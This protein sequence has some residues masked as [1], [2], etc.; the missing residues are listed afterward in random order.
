MNAPSPTSAAPTSAAP[1]A[2]DH[3]SVWTHLLR[4][5]FTQGYVNAGG[6]RTRYIQAGDR[7]APTVIMIPG[8]ASSWE[9]FCANI[10]AHAAHFNCLAFDPVGSGFSE[11]PDVD[12]EIPVYVNHLLAFM[13]AMGVQ[14]ASLIGVSLGAWI[15]ARV[16]V[17]HPKRV[18][19]L[20]L[21]AA[22]G[23][24][25]HAQTMGRIRG[26]RTAA[27]DDPVW[28][29]IKS[30]FTPLIYR[31]EDRIDDIVAVRQVA[32]RQPEMRRAMDH[33]LCLQDPEVRARNLLSEDEWRSIK[34]PVLVVVAPDD[35]EMF[36]NTAMRALKLIPN[37]QSIEIR[38]VKHWPHFERPELFNPASIQFLSSR[39]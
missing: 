38:E 32:Y 7:N 36:Y 21:L 1:A 34:A 18:D 19:K 16:A 30:V 15:A 37:V 25:S 3:R 33:I 22:S 6:V 8:T 12:Y 20:I 23:M 28:P 27:V 35:S 2:A 4:T 31:E 24:I 10:D 5:P 11:K 17:N 29:N 14:K 9:T 26:T 39:R 13:D